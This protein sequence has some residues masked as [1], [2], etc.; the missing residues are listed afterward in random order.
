MNSTKVHCSYMY[1]ISRIRLALLITTIMVFSVSVQAQRI[2]H[3]KYLVEGV[4]RDSST[5]QP[6]SYANLN[7]FDNQRNSVTGALSNEKGSFSLSVDKPGDYTLKISFIGY[8]TKILPIRILLD[9]FRLKIAE[10][11]LS[12]AVTTLK[13]V[14]VSAQKDIIEVHPG[15]LVYNAG[16][17]LTNKGG[18]AADVLRKAPVLNVDAQGN[19]SMRGSTNLKILVDGKYSGQMA[20]NPAD[21]LNMM[22][23]E[24]IK[25]VEVITTPSA[26]YDAEG[27]AG[28]INI[29]TKKGRKDVD[30]AL[31]LTGGNLEQAVNPRIAIAKNK[32]NFSFHGHIHRLRSKEGS[33]YLRTQLENGANTQLEQ[34][35]EQ[36][37]TAPHGS[38][39]LQ[40]TFTPDSS[41]EF[42][43]AVNSSIG[44]WPGDK[45]IQT[46]THSSTGSILEQYSQHIDASERYLS[47]DFNIGYTRKFRTPGRELTILAQTVPRK[48]KDPYYTLISYESNQSQSQEYNTNEIKNRE[49]TF[50]AD[51]IHPFSSKGKYSIESGMKAILRNADNNYQ[52]SVADPQQGG[53]PQIDAARSDRFRYRQNVWSAYM[54]GKANLKY[55]WYAEAGI[56]VEQTEVQGDLLQ[57]GTNFS[58]HFTNFIPTAT[59]SRKINDEHTITLSYTQRLT[60]PSIW[61]LNPNAN[62]SDPKNII[63]G[64]PQLKPE[65]SHQAELVYGLTAG[66]GFFLNSSLYVRQTN[67]AILSFTQTDAN[68]ISTTKKR[69]LASNKV[70]GLNFSSSGSITSNWTVNGNLNVS[71]L[72][73]NSRSLEIVNA[74][75]AAD[76]NLNTTIKLPSKYSLQMFGQYDGRKVTLQGYK[77]RQY[78]YSLAVKKEIPNTKLSIT[79]AFVNPFSSFISQR[80]VIN[81]ASFN[82]EESNR[83]YS[84]AVKFTLN[85]EFGSMFNQRERKK[86]ENDDVNGPLKG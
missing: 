24:I 34:K 81:S 53:T 21:A 42:N 3:S 20:R 28:V 47:S 7:L 30:G 82:S 46:I 62:A 64:N 58:N 48:S 45:E 57:S 12:P 80:S 55:N 67:N 27:A 69:N 70:A 35:V 37:N 76:V 40:I 9:T 26:K 22:P 25:S 52:V 11:L 44:N 43:L 66:S 78:F 65:I 54:M 4:V 79:L 38:G 56:R 16:N 29:I 1:M 73:F 85:W 49:S 31:E 10:V 77:S 63:T 17:D 23:A 86:I 36:D 51:Y 18:T 8:D 14:T 60:R 71:Y 41:S 83:Y 6:V 32:W 75:W 50:Q 74:G 2:D 68:G 39:D 84:R 72:E 13:E 15:M 5:V 59:I 33:T 61:E 19:V